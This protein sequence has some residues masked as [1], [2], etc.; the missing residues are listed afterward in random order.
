VL[1][2]VTAI[3]GTWLAQQQLDQPL[4]GID[5]ANIFFTYA[6]NLAEGEGFVYNQGGERVEG[7]TSLLWTLICAVAF[8]VSARPEPLLL[9]ISTLLLA[10]ALYQSSRFLAESITK[11]DRETRTD[12][13]TLTM[14]LALAAWALATPRFM[15]WTTVT[16][17]DTGLWC[18]VFSCGTIAFSRAARHADSSW[19]RDWPLFGW[20]VAMLLTRPEAMLIVLVWIGSLALVRLSSTGGAE[21]NLLARLWSHCRVPLLGYV[22]TLGALTLFRLVYFGYPLPNTFYAKVSPSLFYNL[23][24]GG[25]YFLA[26]IAS[27][28]FIIPALVIVIRSALLALVRTGRRQP[29][30]DPG[31]VVL[32]AALLAALGIPVITG[33][34]HFNLFRFFQPC[35]LLLALPLL[36]AIGRSLMVRDNPPWTIAALAGCAVLFYSIQY[37]GWNE[38]DD[39]IKVEFKI[40]AHGRQRGELLNQIFA[41]E[42]VSIGVGTAGGI[43]LTYQGQVIDL[44]GLNNIAMGHSPGDRKGGKNHA[45]FNK[46]VFFEQL[47]DVVRPT[48]IQSHQTVPR[49]LE[50]F[51]PPAGG[52]WDVALDGL[53]RSSS[54]FHELYRPTVIQCQNAD[55][56]DLHLRAWCRPHVVELLKDKRVVYQVLD[57]PD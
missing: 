21:G 29:H 5:D 42:K 50:Q 27:Q 18:T 38:L 49:D 44:L 56:T 26:F 40:A 4:T 1:A 19:A 13:L 35:W 37:P 45:A 20:T 23:K 9:G 24:L 53:E 7:F 39:D 16:L 11:Q 43:G 8:L 33:G 32:V 34:D 41:K 46:D 47:P 22:L 48:L 17:M 52:F 51:L 31:Q 54:R 28:L 6:S 3:S 57:S 55:G 10:T 36:V 25:G 2:I 30:K 15:V 12:W 14:L